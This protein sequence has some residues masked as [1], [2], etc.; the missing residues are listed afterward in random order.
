VSGR[1]L[2]VNSRKT[3]RGAGQ[4]PDRVAVLAAPFALLFLVPI[5]LAAQSPLPSKKLAPETAAAFDHYI[6]LAEARIGGAEVRNTTLG[7]GELRIESGGALRDVKVP[8]GIIQDWVGSMFMP[9][10]TLTEVQAVLRDYANYRGFY[11]PKV[12]ESKSLAHHGDDYEVF[13]RLHEEHILSVVLNTT[14]HIRYTMPDEQHLIVTSRSTRIAEVKDPEKSF[15]EE[16]P[17]GHDAGFLW[18]LNSYW[19]FQAADGGVYAR[20]EAISLSRDVPLGLGWMLKGFLESFP[21]ES[22][23]NTL[24]GTREAIKSRMQ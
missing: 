16:L 12:I 3:E 10:A 20:C 8:G 18:R 5:C 9:G 17:A 2:L 19:R 13:L 7:S 4:F 15:D 21:K 1:W 24:G 11:Q 23:L 6:E 22:M 14:Y